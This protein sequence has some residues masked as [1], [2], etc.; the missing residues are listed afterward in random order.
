MASTGL[1]SIGATGGLTGRSIP[2]ASLV[3]TATRGFLPTPSDDH[4]AP[5]PSAHM[6]PAARPAGPASRAGRRPGR[7]HAALVT[8][9]TRSQRRPLIAA[10]PQ[11]GG[12]LGGRD[13]ARR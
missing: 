8:A 13:L 12:Q 3:M 5:P 6:R 1:A 11:L 2:P 10:L 4:A 7:N 9:P